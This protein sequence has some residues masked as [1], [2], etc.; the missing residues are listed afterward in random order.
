MIRTLFAVLILSLAGLMVQSCSARYI[1]LEMKS[2]CDTV[3]FEKLPDLVKETYK[4]YFNNLNHDRY[5]AVDTSIHVQLVVVN[6]DSRKYGWSPGY[7]FTINHRKVSI[8]YEPRKGL[9]FII[10]HKY[11]Y[12]GAELNVTEYNYEKLSYCRMKWARGK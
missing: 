12:W 6:Y 5:K 9:P 11:V 1:H 7:Y 3:A 4:A 10:D 2:P 8:N